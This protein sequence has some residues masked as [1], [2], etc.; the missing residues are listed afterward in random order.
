MNSRISRRGFVAGATIAAA[1]AATAGSW[2]FDL[3]FPEEAFADPNS[4]V[5]KHL[6]YCDM[7]NQV[8]KCGL[9]AHVRE[10]KVIRV[11][12]P[13]DHPVQPLCAKGIASLQELYDPHRLLHPM[14][15]TN[16]R[17]NSDPAWTQITWDEAYA[18][19]AEK[20]NAVKEKYGPQS[21]LF[22]CGDP[23][24]PRGALQ[25]LATAFGSPTYGT[26]S[27]TCSVATQMGGMLAMGMGTMGANPSD[28]SKSCLIWSLNPAWSQPNRFGVLMDIKEKTG[29]KFVI[30]DPRVTPTVTGLA[31]IH[32]QVRPGADSALALGLAH[33][34]FRDEMYDKDF[35]ENWMLGL[36]EFK[37]LVQEWTPE[38]TAEAT[39]IPK[40]KLEAAVKMLWENRPTQLITSSSPQVHHTNAGNI[41]RGLLTVYA[42]LGCLD[43]NGGLAMGGGGGTPSDGNNKF[44]LSGK[45]ET[46]C[47]PLRLDALDFPVW[48]ELNTQMQINKFPEYV[49]EGKIKA[50]LFVGTNSMMWPDTPKYQQAMEALEFSAAVDYYER[51][52][53]H[54]HCDIILPAAISY[55]RMAPLAVHGRKVYLRTPCVA[56]QGEAREDWQISFEL[57]TAMGLGD[58]CFNGSVE[59]SLRE[60]ITTSGCNFT[61]EELRDAPEGY[62]EVEGR[63]SEEK[64]YASGKLRSDGEPGF[65]TPSKKFEIASERLKKHNMEPLPVHI[66]PRYN[67][68]DSPEAK[69]YPLI[70]NTGSRLPFY[71]HSKLRNIPWLRTLQPDPV[72][73]LAIK[74]AEERGIEN[75]EWVRVFNWQ[76]EIEM[77]AEVTNLLLP[78][79]VDIYHGW[80]QADVNLLTTR[81]FDPITGFPPFKSGLCQ[82]AKKA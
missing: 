76:G 42:L 39:W 15:R 10:N 68:I 78:G 45:Y 73:R 63:P 75:G 49:A 77:V 5:E 79:M 11:E 72:V 32:L 20:L 16:S 43:V 70:L 37:V 29:C 36:E 82:V 56:P 18:T 64:K 7:C 69:E 19:I 2:V 34:M 24:E 71:T 44:Q 81:D 17:P 62:I 59:D 52:W 53:T 4:E 22:F 8:P 50:A 35:A 9:L 41:Q 21:V 58:A 51:D 25:R 65:N 46:E 54:P 61:F 47:R 13:K 27:S 40:E 23:K 3:G 33:I 60:V 12:S 74:D 38:K 14:K 66:E 67:P 48:A 6:T 31:D 80:P 30:V 1:A 55:E 57:G 28:A 26:E